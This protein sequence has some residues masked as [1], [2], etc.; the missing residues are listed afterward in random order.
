M[1]FL[2]R[3]L[4]DIALLFGVFLSKFEAAMIFFRFFDLATQY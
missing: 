2:A 1:V 3:R 4:I